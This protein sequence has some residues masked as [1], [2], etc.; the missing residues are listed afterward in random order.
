MGQYDYGEGEYHNYSVRSAVRATGDNAHDLS[1]ITSPS[2][3]L[4]VA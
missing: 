1:K 3:N 4:T 2:D